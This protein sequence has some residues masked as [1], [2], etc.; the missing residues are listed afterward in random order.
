MARE[1][2]HKEETIMFTTLLTF[3]LIIFLLLPLLIC[4]RILKPRKPMGHLT[5]LLLKE[6]IMGVWNWIFGAKKMRVAKRRKK[7]WWN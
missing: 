4:W 7:R 3:R 6:M 2:E 5:A 1:L